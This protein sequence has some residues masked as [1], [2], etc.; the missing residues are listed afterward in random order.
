MPERTSISPRSRSNMSSRRLDAKN[1]T[2]FGSY[3]KFYQN[4]YRDRLH[5]ATGHWSRSA[6]TTTATTAR[7]C[8]ARPISSGKTAWRDRPDVAV[9]LRG[10]ARRSRATSEHGR[11]PERQHDA[12]AIRRSTRRTCLRAD[13]ERRQQPRQGDRRGR[14][15]P[16]PDPPADWLEIVAGLRFDSFKLYVTILRPAGG[17]ISAG[18]TS[19]G[20]RASA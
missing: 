11:V 18:G 17:G 5:A 4:I 3:D 20:R 8:S 2:L 9:G 10:R 16:G 13:R 14:L 7:T 15:H 1:H 6:P 12:D 19:S